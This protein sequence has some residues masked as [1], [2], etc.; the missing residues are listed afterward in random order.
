M[1]AVTRVDDCLVEIIDVE[2]VLTEVS[3]S[4]EE[5]LTDSLTE[6]VRISALSKK[7]TDR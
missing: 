1:T 2:K 3:P 6:Q 7:N 4:S 5:I